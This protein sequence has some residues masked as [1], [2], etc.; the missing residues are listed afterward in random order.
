MEVEY[1]IL[2]FF[3][4]FLLIIELWVI[5]LVEV[6]FLVVWWVVLLF[7]FFIFLDWDD[8]IFE[9]VF[10]FYVDVFNLDFKFIFIVLEFLG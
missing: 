6:L 9:M 2:Y 7:F 8:G 1:I 10:S 5:V 4:F 3:K